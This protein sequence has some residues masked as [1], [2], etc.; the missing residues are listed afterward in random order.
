MK[1]ITKK[2][3]NKE[4]SRRDYFRRNYVLRGESGMVHHGVQTFE[5]AWAY[6]E[7]GDITIYDYGYGD[8]K[9]R[10]VVEL[11]DG[12][13]SI[14][15]TDIITDWLAWDS[16]YTRQDTVNRIYEIVNA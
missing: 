13:R 4:L 6:I 9:E 12:A 7:N 15:I 10:K 2:A 11:Q 14:D 16:Y 3:I 1:H 5:S 8:A